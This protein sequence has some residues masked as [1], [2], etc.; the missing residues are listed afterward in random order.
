LL[1]THYD[2]VII[3]A[4]TP[5]V[6][7]RGSIRLLKSS[8][9]DRSI[10]LI[11]RLLTV[12]SRAY[13]DNPV[14]TVKAF[15]EDGN[16]IWVPR[17]CAPVLNEVASYGYDHIDDTSLGL[18]SDLSLA[19]KL[20]PERG[21]PHIF[22]KMVS[23]LE[24]NK[25]GTLQAPTGLG[26]TFLGYAIGHHFGRHIGVFVYNSHM[27][28]NWVK[29]ASV[30]F[31]IPEEDIGIVKEGRCD[32]DKPV[33]VM[34]VQSLLSREYPAELYDKFG[35]LV[36]DEVH[37]YSS[38]MWGKVVSKFSA[39]YRLGLSATPERPD[40]LESVFYWNFGPIGY[41]AKKKE[42]L[43]KPSVVQVFY[44]G[45][46]PFRS[47]C[48]WGVDP[49]TGR[50][51]PTDQINVQRYRKKLSSD[52]RR[53]EM[54]IREMIN[55]RKKGRRA[56]V[57]SQFR[58]HVIELKDLFDAELARTVIDDTTT[59]LLIGGIK[60]LEE[61]MSADF[62]FTTFSFSREGLNIV[63]IDTLFFA[64][65]PGNPTQPVGRLR[66]VGEDKKPLL[67]IDVYEDTGYSKNRARARRNVYK[68]LGLKVGRVTRK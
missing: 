66:D 50:M 11:K 12:E 58:N 52:E 18:K 36:A 65:P 44:E 43:E 39:R 31:G 8:F 25:A 67:A 51:V 42:A 17:H 21:Q 49:A 28:D 33:T 2:D 38:R 55:A 47:Y 32:L 45:S 15:R 1:T 35:I 57:M 27:M 64:T 7:T 16:F 9:D 59:S 60:N 56:L 46:Y 37:R 68:D 23:Y 30:A 61:A 24:N 41:V 40:G 54:L 4:K 3:T 29:S 20:L 53:N 10:S 22:N 48:K 6:L 14:I 34:M 5:D 62:I 26:K 13:Q 19:I 63:H